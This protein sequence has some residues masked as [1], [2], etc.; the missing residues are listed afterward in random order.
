MSLVRRSRARKVRGELIV[1]RPGVLTTD[2]YS[3]YNHFPVGERQACGA[4]LRRD[5]QAMIDRRTTAARK[6]R[7]D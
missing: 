6:I 7:I 3:V 1:G 2:R 4:H 5:F